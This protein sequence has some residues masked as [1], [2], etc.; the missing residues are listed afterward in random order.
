MTEPVVASLSQSAVEAQIKAYESGLQKFI[1]HLKCE[2]ENGQ[3]SGVNRHY[4][5]MSELPLQ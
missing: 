3:P 1:A 2:L 5:E 4:A